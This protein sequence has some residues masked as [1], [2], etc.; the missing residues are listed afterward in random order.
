MASGTK[1]R[2]CHVEKTF[3]EQE[4]GFNLHA[5]RGRGQFIG[6]VDAGSPADLARLKSGDRIYAVNGS[7]V[8]SE[9]HK[10]VCK[11]WGLL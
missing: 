10:Q 3:P 6:S 2:L 8:I 11:K 5:E 4:Y 7:S 1:P 9:G